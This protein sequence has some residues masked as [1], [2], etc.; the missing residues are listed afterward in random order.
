M[1]PEPTG[2]TVEQSSATLKSNDTIQRGEWE[3]SLFGCFTHLIPNCCMVSCCPCVSQ[4]QIASRIGWLSYSSGII[5]FGLLFL[6]EWASLSVISF[7]KPQENH[8]TFFITYGTLLLV[9]VVV[10]IVL[11]K[12]R[13][14]VRTLFDIRGNLFLDCCAI[15]WCSCCATAQ[16][17]THVKSY[18]PGSCSFGPPDV[19][20]PYKYEV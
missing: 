20:Q 17:A 16:M 2:P 12:L 14:E 5:V 8:T 9:T 11:I 6:L 10:M 15:L 19:L 1:Y 4:A 7:V 3:T 18:Q 13:Y